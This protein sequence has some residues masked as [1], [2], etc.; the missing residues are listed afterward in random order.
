MEQ[1]DN[2]ARVRDLAS[3]VWYLP[4]VRTAV[5]KHLEAQGAVK[6]LQDCLT[7]NKETSLDVALVLYPAILFDRF[8]W[9]CTDEVRTPFR[10]PQQT[11]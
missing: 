6:F 10:Y 7:L 5:F 2:R 11:C 4:H 1:A 9:N 8:P 3:R